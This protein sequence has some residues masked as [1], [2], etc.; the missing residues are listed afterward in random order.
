MIRP[1]PDNT[2][3]ASCETTLED[4]LKS[5]VLRGKHIHCAFPSPDGLFSTYVKRELKKQGAE[6][7]FFKDTG[8]VKIEH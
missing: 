2:L 6:S 7:I 3:Y 4:L 8:T 1:D 5:P